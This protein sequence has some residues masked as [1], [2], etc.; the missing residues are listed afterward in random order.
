[1]KSKMGFFIM[2]KMSTPSTLDNRSHYHEAK[3]ILCVGICYTTEGKR[4]ICVERKNAYWIWLLLI[5]IPEEAV[6]DEAEDMIPPNEN[7]GKDAPILAI[8]TPADVASATKEPISDEELV[9]QE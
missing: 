6:A 7:I 8:S 2:S 9:S 4:P 3:V 1:M 5:T